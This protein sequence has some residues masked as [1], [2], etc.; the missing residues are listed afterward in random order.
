MPDVQLVLIDGRSG[1]GKTDLANRLGELWGA[2]VVHLDDAYPGWDGLEAGRDA[3]IAGVVVPLSQ[4]RAGEY[5]RWNWPENDYGDVVSV[6]VAPIVIIEGCG[7]ACRATAE[8]ADLILWVECADDIRRMRAVERDGSTTAE[9]FDRW[10]AQE[11]AVMNRE[12]PQALADEIIYTDQRDDELGG[13]AATIG[14]KI[15]GPTEAGPEWG[16]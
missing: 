4:G 8:I 11:L 5:R 10:A 7:I 2:P 12:F 3:I 9:N 6:P 14:G 13:V 15:M 1:A 16:G